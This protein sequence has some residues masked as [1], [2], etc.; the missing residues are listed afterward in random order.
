[1][2]PPLAVRPGRRLAG[3][4]ALVAIDINTNRK[5]YKSGF[6]KAFYTDSRLQEQLAAFI[7]ADPPSVLWR[8]QGA[9]AT[10][11]RFLAIRFLGQPDSVLHCESFHAQW[12]WLEAAKRALKFKSLNAF[13][14][15]GAFLRFNNGSFP[16][17]SELVPHI[18]E[19]RRE[20]QA[21][22]ERARAAHPDHGRNHLNSVFAYRFNLRPEDYTLLNASA[23]AK[24]QDGHTTASE[25]WGY[26]I[27]FLFE[28][29]KFYCF[30]TLGNRILY[31][32][33]TKSV[34]NRAPP[35]PFDAIGRP[36]CVCWFKRVG[37]TGD[38][39][40]VTPDEVAPGAFAVG[41]PTGQT[42]PDLGRPSCER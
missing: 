8:N 28:K 32:A 19:S 30:Q 22:L 23:H 18:R 6:E 21:A 29:N 17:S 15:I 1:M 34:P 35:K 5:Q 37:D 7:T 26:Y 13:L 39:L 42:Y 24:L 36:L 4:P 16:P 10:L 14:K 33:E 41:K 27:R 3:R 9:Y 31:V 12:K 2:V 20:L 40:H 38:G 25:A 11:F